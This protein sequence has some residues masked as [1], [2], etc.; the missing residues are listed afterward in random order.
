M[1]SLSHFQLLICLGAWLSAGTAIPLHQKMTADELAQL[2]GARSPDQVPEYDLITPY[3]VDEEGNFHS[4]DLTTSHLRTRRSDFHMVK[5]VPAHFKVDAFGKTHQLSVLPND[6]LLGPGFLVQIHLDNG[7]IDTDFD[8]SICQYTGTVKHQEDSSH[9]AISNY[10]GKLMGVIITNIT[11]LMIHPLPDH[12][13]ADG[14]SNPNNHTH[15]VYRRQ[16]DE[17]I[18]QAPYGRA[19][20][21]VEGSI[22]DKNYTEGKDYKNAVRN[23][24]D[25]PGG[26]SGQGEYIIE[27][28][29]VADAE[30]YKKFGYKGNDVKY[31]IIS[32]MNIASSMYNFKK[33]GFN[34]RLILTRV[35][36][37]T[38]ESAQRNQKLYITQNS[39]PTLE[40]FCQWQTNNK[41][42]KS[43]AL[44]YDHAFLFTGY[45][46]CFG[47]N[48]DCWE[49]GRAW[50]QGMC[51]DKFACSVNANKGLQLGFVFAHELGHNLGMLHDGANGR[52]R[53]EDGYAMKSSTGLAQNIYLWSSCSKNYLANYLRNGN[54]ACLSDKPA[55]FFSSFGAENYR[56]PGSVYTIDQQ[57]KFSWGSQATFCRKEPRSLDN[58]VN[59]VCNHLYCD[60]K[61]W[62]RC[63]T[64]YTGAP[65]GTPCGDFSGRQICYDR[66]CVSKSSVRNPLLPFP[67]MF[68]PKLSYR[69]PDGNGVLPPPPK[70]VDTTPV[71]HAGGRNPLP[72]LKPT[73]SPPCIPRGRAVHGRW[74]EWSEPSVCTRT[75]G[76]GFQRQDRHCDN[77]TPANCGRD[78]QGDSTRY[79]LCNTKPCTDKMDFRLKQCRRYASIVPKGVV[80]VP[81]ENVASGDRC[82]L[83]CVSSSSVKYT[84]SG[85]EVDGGTRCDS[86]P[87]SNDRCLLG[88]CLAVGCDNV[89]GSRKKFDKCGVCGGNSRTC[90]KVKV[91]EVQTSKV[92]GSYNIFHQWAGHYMVM[93]IPAKASDILIEG[94]RKVIFALF[95]GGIRLIKFS[96]QSRSFNYEN[97]VFSYKAPKSGQITI[98]AKGPLSSAVTIKMLKIDVVDRTRPEINYS[99]SLPSSVS[100]T[101]S[102]YEWT[103]VPGSCSVTC[104]KAQGSQEST[105]KCRRKS[106]GADAADRF[107]ASAENILSRRRRCNIDGKPCPPP[108]TV[109]WVEG[110]WSKCSVSCGKGVRARSV[111]CRNLKA[112]SVVA[113]GLCRSDKPATTKEACSVKPC[114]KPCK[115]KNRGICK[116]L[117]KCSSCEKKAVKNF[118]TCSC[119]S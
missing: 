46:M 26:A 21:D 28:M 68:H 91:P 52:C 110:D 34:I 83:Q 112:K 77:P 82:K 94:N 74:S 50:I 49:L 65:D 64:T 67:A 11:T 31:Y 70:G 115:D 101:D 119:K 54:T 75:C 100:F 30:L 106:D 7:K 33:L 13:S 66:R 117:L 57:C 95:S 78:C 84:L 48:E 108:P 105:R 88:K 43:S 10:G 42:D 71:P 56:F 80:L 12:H 27:A 97:T 104:G 8:Y 9:V 93:T 20:C 55:H 6:K 72:N 58:K 76:G 36:I 23:G 39:K 92:Q 109:D 51:R 14:L 69:D 113:D 107:C 38:S 32:L 63:V 90:P 41:P 62:P 22:P 53:A 118:C 81:K 1:Y 19:N 99:F 116:L 24:E 59:D 96:H 37:F 2:L 45:G 5:D 60:D 29:V 40:N 111:V 103:L 16:A 25:L 4:H 73:V 3:Q 98:S 86:D 89:M 35:A 47:R 18:P 85:A 15:I 87:T 102:A 17:E 79:T 44:T 114:E 61:D